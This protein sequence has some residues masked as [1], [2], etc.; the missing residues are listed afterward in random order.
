M[1]AGN[2]VKISWFG[3]A[4]AA[5]VLGLTGASFQSTTHY[6]CGPATALFASGYVKQTDWW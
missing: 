5:I 1:P 2:G 3:W 6:S 4:A